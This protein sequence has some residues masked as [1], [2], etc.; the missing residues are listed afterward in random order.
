MPTVFDL[1]QAAA[2]CRMEARRHAARDETWVE[3]TALSH[4]ERLDAIAATLRAEASTVAPC[5]RCADVP[6]GQ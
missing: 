2:F 6:V 1:E 3:L 5:Y 4:A